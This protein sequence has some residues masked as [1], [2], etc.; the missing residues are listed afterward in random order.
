MQKCSTV[1]DVKNLFNQYNRSAWSSAVLRFVDKTGKFLYV[2]GDSLIISDK[3]IFV[4]TNVRPCENKKC[5]RLE[6]A[7][8]L[9]SGDYEATIEYCKAMMDSVHQEGNWGGTL[10]TTIYDLDKLTIDLYYFYDYENMVTF[11]L[12]EELKKGDRIIE[13]PQLFPN[14]SIGMR[15][16]TEYNKILPMLKQFGDSM[17]NNSQSY[18]ALKDSINSSFIEHYAFI[19]K[20]YDFGQY[21]LNENIDFERAILFYRLYTE[22]LPKYWKGFDI[23]G[24]AYMRNNQYQLALDNYKRSIELKPDNANAKKQIEILN[25]LIKK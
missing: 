16:Y 5:W 10:Y 25:D 22:L 8:R 21:Y 3:D 24:T 20:L 19:S 12:K 9:L 18:K 2:D 17:S 23:L 11:N 6:K 14:N 1:E 4:Q 13:I 7:S 15:Y